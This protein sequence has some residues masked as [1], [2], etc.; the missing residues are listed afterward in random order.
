MLYAKIIEIDEHSV[1]VYT[2]YAWCG[3]QY[4]YI[5]LKDIRPNNIISISQRLKR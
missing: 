1:H 4:L 2:Y 5:I 3:I